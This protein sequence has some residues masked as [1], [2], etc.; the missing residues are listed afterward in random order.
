MQIMICDNPKLDLVKMNAFIIFGE[1]MSI[2]S[3]DI[4]R[5]LNFH[6]NQGP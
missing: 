6:L 3:Q 4:E 1:K 2:G 5:K